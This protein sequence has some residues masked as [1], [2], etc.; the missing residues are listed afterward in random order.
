MEKN[1]IGKKALCSRYTEEK[2]IASSG[3]GSEPYGD[4]CADCL[5]ASSNY[6]C[7]ICD[8]EL[9]CDAYESHLLQEHSREQMAKYI[10]IDSK[11]FK[12][13]MILSF[14]LNI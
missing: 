8:K 1:N 14:R 11:R 5:E 7:D 13:S 6:A 12:D 2:I 3:F 10:S 9:K 4:L